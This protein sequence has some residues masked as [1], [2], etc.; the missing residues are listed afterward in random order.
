MT[1]KD[2]FKIWAP[3]GCEWTDWVRPVPFITMR[4][5]NNMNATMNLAMPAIFYLNKTRNH[6]AIILDLPGYDGV[7]EGLSLASLG[8]RPIPLYNGTSGQNGAAALIDFHAIESALIW[9]AS[10]LEKLA[11]RRDAPPAFLLDSNRMF[12]FRMN[13]SVFDNSWDLYGQD[14]PSAKYFI[15][16]G[17]TEIIVRGEKIQRDLVRILYP[18]QK[19]GMKILF[20]NG[21]K[22]PETTKIKKPPRKYK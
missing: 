17:I 14:M 1:G 22:E 13:A 3:A 9:G 12:R 11:I 15:H 5:F 7:K 4:D 6:T 10:E 8:F 16:N 18:F 19:E 20:T 21:F 2:I